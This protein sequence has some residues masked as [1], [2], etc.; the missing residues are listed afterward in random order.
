MAP[1]T[2]DY[3]AP[4]EAARLLR[5]SP[6]TL[7]RWI[8]AGR[9]PYERSESGQPRLGREHVLQLIDPPRDERPGDER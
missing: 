9:I 5:M 6:R 3:L 4:M 7:R 8:E 1:P 2:D